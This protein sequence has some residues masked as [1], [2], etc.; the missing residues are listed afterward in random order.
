MW[1]WWPS[2]R[3]EM[4]PEDSKEELGMKSTQ[5]QGIS[6]LNDEELAEIGLGSINEYTVFVSERGL[7]GKCI[8][9]S[10]ISDAYQ[11]RKRLGEYRRR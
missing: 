5:G 2:L 10:S 4:L 7:S 8:Y 6:Q 11:L 1:Q 9:S 3:G